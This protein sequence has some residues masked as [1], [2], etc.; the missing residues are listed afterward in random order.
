MTSVFCRRAIIPSLAT[1][2]PHLSLNINTTRTRRILDSKFSSC[3]HAL[4]LTNQLPR[5]IQRFLQLCQCLCN[6]RR[7]LATTPNH[8][9]AHNKSLTL[10]SSYENYIQDSGQH[11]ICCSGDGDAQSATYNKTPSPG[12]LLGYN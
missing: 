3:A 6:T 1:R 9:A 11:H 8:L 7:C 2:H 5:S 4:V 12:H 10:S